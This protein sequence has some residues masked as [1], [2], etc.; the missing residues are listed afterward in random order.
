M[1]DGRCTVWCA[2]DDIA[3]LAGAG[4]LAVVGVGHAV[5]AAHGQ[6]H[7]LQGGKARGGK[8]LGAGSEAVVAESA[9]NRRVPRQILLASEGRAAG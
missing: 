2:D 9:P 8:Q 3:V 6:R 4:A 1:A 7:G 5:A